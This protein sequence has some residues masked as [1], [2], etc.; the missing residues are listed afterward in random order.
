MKA[1]YRVGFPFWKA[2]ARAGKPVEFRVDVYRDNDAGV[3]LANSPDLRGLH[4][5]A[6]SLD[7]LL[8]E[9]RGAA[10]V[11]LELAISGPRGRAYPQLRYHDAALCAA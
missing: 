1:V 8:Q 3:Y 7:E 10:D 2:V 9:V 5:E 11:L 6:D 4:V